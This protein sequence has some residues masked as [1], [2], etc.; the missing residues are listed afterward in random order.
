MTLRGGRDT[1]GT[2]QARRLSEVEIDDEYF[3][4]PADEV[5]SDGRVRRGEPLRAGGRPP[6]TP[7]RGPAGFRFGGLLRFL[8]F[9]CALAAFVLVVALTVL[10]P[11]VA[12]AVVGWASD[13]PSALRLPFV[14]DLVREDLGT[15]L[16]K[17]ASADPSEIEFTVADGDTAA[18]IASRLAAQGFLGD[19]RAFV[20]ITTERDLAGKLE[21][22][23][24]ILRRNMTPD[25]LVTA[26]LVARDQAITVGLRESLRIEQ[27]SAKL[28]TLPLTMDVKAFYD[29]AMHPPASLLNDYSWLNLPKG[30]S[31]EGFLAAATYRVLPNISPDALI[32]R[33]LDRFYGTVGPDRLAVPAARGLSFYEV[34]S[35]ASIVEQ[36]AV[37]D[38]ERPLIAGVYQNRLKT[39]PYILNADPTVI[40]ANDTMQLGKLPFADWPTY[41][42]W[43]LPGG[44][45]ADV[46]VPKALQGYQ[47]YQTPGLIPGPIC[48]PTIASIDAAL[49]PDTKAGYRYF[50]AIPKGGG[51]H[52]FSK[53]YAEHL[54]KLRKYGYQ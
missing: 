29:E 22:G 25:E 53:T 32:R 49:H 8:L 26:L 47:T 42:F 20:F 18:S 7:R 44:A 19:A 15:A 40:Y 34:L 3:A 23:T 4:R 10:R 31:L 16:T 12:K 54:A 37:V 2:P 33:M 46:K 35:L 17:A 24:Y 41:A 13:N 52:D 21:A 28:L 6:R 51:R 30:A 9:A 39:R 1:R 38:T 48:T 50:V 43:S 5:P 14:A 11:V 36:E 45:L 27:I